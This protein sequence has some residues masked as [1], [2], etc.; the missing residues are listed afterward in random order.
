MCARTA[1]ARLCV[2]G[3]FAR[4]CFRAR[5]TSLRRGGR[6]VLYARP[7][8]KRQ[9]GLRL[10]SGQF[11][12]ARRRRPVAGRINVGGHAE[13]P[14][15]FTGIDRAVVAGCR[16]LRDITSRRPFVERVGRVDLLQ[17]RTRAELHRR[18]Q[19]AKSLTVEI[20]ALKR[21]RLR[22]P[23]RDLPELSVV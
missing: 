7:R 12:V 3:V 13:W 18:L 22:A 11:A 21:I 10:G 23:L 5:R 9:R 16:D 14:R 2:R 4:R 19:H 6:V 1:G 8:D 17:A 15:P 20:H